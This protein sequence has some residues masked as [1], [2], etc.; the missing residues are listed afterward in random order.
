MAQVKGC[1]GTNQARVT[2]L[3]FGR[4]RG[5]DGD[6]ELGFEGGSP[7]PDLGETVAEGP[8]NVVNMML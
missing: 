6:A 2:W 7:D 5:A 8:K 4:G 1:G 3:R